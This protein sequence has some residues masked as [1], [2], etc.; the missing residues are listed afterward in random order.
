MIE[1][2]RTNVSDFGQKYFTYSNSEVDSCIRNRVFG[3]TKVFE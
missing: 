2:I 1:A 3:A